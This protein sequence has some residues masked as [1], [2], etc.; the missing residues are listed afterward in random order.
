MERGKIIQHVVNFLIV[1]FPSGIQMFN[2][3]NIAGDE[4]ETIFQSRDVSIDY[5]EDYDYIEI[6][7]L[8]ESEFQ[9]IK[10]IVDYKIRIVDTSKGK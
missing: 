3:R 6:F 10:L 4:M 1:E 2:C 5:C 8:S 7:G 9:M